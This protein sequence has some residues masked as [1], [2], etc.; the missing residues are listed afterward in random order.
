MKP[1]QNQKNLR[2]KTKRFIRQTNPPPKKTTDWSMEQ[3]KIKF[4]KIINRTGNDNNSYKKTVNL[5]L[6]YLQTLPSPYWTGRRSCGLDSFVRDLSPRPSPKV[7]ADIS[8]QSTSVIKID[9]T[10]LKSYVKKL[11]FFIQTKLPMI[12]CP[13]NRQI[14]C[15]H[16]CL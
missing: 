2:P 15:C 1:L 13:I 8:N 16:V 4:T 6:L 5:L 9:N 10:Y 11:I 7:E 3:K 12:T 14:K